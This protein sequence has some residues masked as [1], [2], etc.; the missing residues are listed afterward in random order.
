MPKYDLKG[1][2]KQRQKPLQ[3]RLH[4]HRM[5]IKKKKLQVPQGSV[6]H[7]RQ[8]MGKVVERN[9]DTILIEEEIGITLDDTLDNIMED[10]IGNAAD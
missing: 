3:K 4:R 5:I 10:A 7:Q 8:N 9:Q 1:S 2:Q 6:Q